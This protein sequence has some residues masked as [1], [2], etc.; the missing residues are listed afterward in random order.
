M[1]HFAFRPCVEMKFLLLKTHPIVLKTFLIYLGLSLVL[2]LTPSRYTGPV[3]DVVLYP[4][5]LLQHGVLRSVRA[6][7]AAAG[8]LKA[9]RGAGRKA[10]RLRERV[11]ELET[12]LAE[13]TA[14]RKTA[15][16]RLAQLA[17]IPAEIRRRAL[18]ATVIAFGPVPWRRTALLNKGSRSGIVADSPVLWYGT[19]IGRV[20][21]V[22]P[23]RCRAVLLG[24]PNCRVAVRCARSRVRG[25]LEGIGGGLCIVKY[26]D[27]LA[28][29]RPG[30][31]FVTSGLDGIFPAGHRVGECSRASAESGEIFMR[32]EVKPALNLLRLDD[33]VVLLP[34]AREDVRNR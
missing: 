6:A 10:A 13:E 4:F 3:R 12:R 28:D 7:G 18:A 8:G 9:L 21:S 19:A 26:I 30:D 29:I 22:G 33:V 34:E 24:D 17:P 20:D 5:A 32:V 15:E 14:A 16:S 31:V 25:I 23:L 27:L 2:L 11:A 1:F